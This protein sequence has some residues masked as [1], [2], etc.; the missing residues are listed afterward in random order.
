MTSAPIPTDGAAIPRR[1]RL[2]RR[3]VAHTLG[4]AA[5]ALLSWLV[6]RAYRQPGFML[7]LLNGFVLC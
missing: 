7:D 5:A 6:W 2:S 1:S 4:L 3:L